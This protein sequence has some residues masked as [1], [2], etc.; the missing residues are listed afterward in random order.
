V[1]VDALMRELEDQVLGRLRERL[2]E[3]GGPR[4]YEDAELFRAVEEVLRRA[5]A[6]RSLDAL[7]VPELLRDDDEWQLRT[8]LRLSSH[9]PGIG[10]LIVFVKRHLLLPL[11]R[12]LYEYSLE[13]FR[14]QERVN[15]LL[16]SCVEELAI[17][18]ARLRQRVQRL[19]ART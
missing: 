16:F 10:K 14:R 8:Y 17:E 18:N 13:N 2:M 5:V 4:E 6:D 12:W 1:R 3:S 7:L 9:R 15:R 11:T 19:S